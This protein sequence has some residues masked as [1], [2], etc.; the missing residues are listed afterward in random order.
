MPGLFI[1]INAARNNVTKKPA[2]FNV[3]IKVFLKV[4]PI[5]PEGQLITFNS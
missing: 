5:P 3:D 2:K 4:W 1:G